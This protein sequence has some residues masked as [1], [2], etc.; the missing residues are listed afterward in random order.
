MRLRLTPRLGIA[1]LF[2]AATPFATSAQQLASDREIRD[3]LVR[4][5]MTGQ[6]RAIV[7]GIYDN[8]QARII[9]MGASEAPNGKLDGN[10]VFEIG[11]ITKVF[12]GTL[13]ADMAA[14]KIVSVDDSVAKYLPTAVRMPSRN[15][16]AI[17][18]LDL[19]TQHSGLP[20]MPNNMLPVDPANPY[21]DY[22][23]QQMYEFLSRHELQRDPGESFEYSNLGVGLL[24]A[25]LARRAGVSYEKLVTDQI[26]D[27]LGM[28]NTR[29][30][31]TAEMRAALARP[32]GPN[33]APTLNWDLPTLAGAGALRSTANDMLRF[34]AAA[35]GAPGTPAELASALA[36]AERPRRDIS[37]GPMAAQIGLNWFTGRVGAIDIVWH[38]GGTGGYRAFLGLDKPRQRA[39]VVL[40]NSTVGVDEIGRHILDPTVPLGR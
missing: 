38:N 33:G 17:T 35:L 5:V 36:E 28:R 26:L 22:T 29:V 25:A 12:T 20:R 13:L 34:A 30:V 24:G 9:P 32:Y 18:L 19:S 23:P 14:R 40:T 21:A 31:L 15:G 3:A 39:V 10:T 11:S 6:N 1:A 7:V 37:L 16:R 27:P 2:I 4:R 8:G